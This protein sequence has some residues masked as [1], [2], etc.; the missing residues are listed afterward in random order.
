MNHLFRELA[1]I[2]PQGWAA[3]DEEAA[4]TLKRTLA[5]RR[6]VDFS[7]PHGFNFSTVGTGRTRRVDEPRAGVIAALREAQPLVELTA[8]FRLPRTEIDAL[9]RGA[10]DADLGPVT[11]AARMAAL[12]EDGAIF[13]GFAAGGI[14]GIVERARDQALPLTTEYEK[15]PRVVAAA[16]TQL[17]KQGIDGPYAIALGPRCYQGLTETTNRGGY[18]V[19]DLVKQQL[20]GRIVWAPAVDGAVVLSTR[21]GDFEL[22]VGQDFSIGYSAHDGEHVELYVQETAT[23]IAYTPEAAVPL[24]YES[25]SSG[26]EQ[27]KAAGT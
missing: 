21:G 26:G 1:P 23:F 17:R 19:M 15:Y 4:R 27:P 22:I 3:I 25:A 18:P 5:G 14:H 20:D 10:E 6:L 24:L 11:T 8:P 13:N 9:A 16:L 2:D 7:G 12:A